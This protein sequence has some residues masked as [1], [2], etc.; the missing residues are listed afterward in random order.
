MKCLYL[1]N[2]APDTMQGYCYTEGT[3]LDE[4]IDLNSYIVFSRKV[5]ARSPDGF[6]FSSLDTRKLPNNPY[7]FNSI[8]EM[9]RLRNMPSYNNKKKV[10]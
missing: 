4:A 2:V 3:T 7:Y 10:K 6:I 1:Y 8:N 5:K 9:I